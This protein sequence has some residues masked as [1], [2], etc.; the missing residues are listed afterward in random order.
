MILKGLHFEK[1]RMVNYKLANE[2]K[3]T[4]F[5]FELSLKTSTIGVSGDYV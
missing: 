4:N 5:I 2:E 3:S 1:N